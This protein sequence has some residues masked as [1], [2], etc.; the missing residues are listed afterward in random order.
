MNTQIYVSLI[1]FPIIG[2][3]SIDMMYQRNSLNG[4]FDTDKLFPPTNSTI[5]NKSYNIYWHK[6]RFYVTYHLSENN[7]DSIGDSL[8]NFI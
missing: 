6:W 3:H 5:Q 2:R 4:K 1:V 8:S 7:S